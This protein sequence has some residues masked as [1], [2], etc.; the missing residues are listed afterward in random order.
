MNADGEIR[1]TCQ[2]YR[3]QT[4]NEKSCFN[5]MQRYVDDACFAAAGLPT[6]EERKQTRIQR[7]KAKLRS[8]ALKK[9]GVGP[10]PEQL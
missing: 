3:T 7:S 8:R 1:V 2:K 5:M 10:E 4:E 6:R 9:L